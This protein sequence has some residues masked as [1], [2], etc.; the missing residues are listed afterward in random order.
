MKPYEKGNIK[1]AKKLRSEQTEWENKFWFKFLRN[2]PVRFQ[3]QKAIGKYIV[4]F[5]CAKAKLVIELDGSQH[6]DDKG[7]E[8]DALRTAFLEQYGLKV[9]RI[10]NLD[11]N[12]NFN[13]IK[14]LYEQGLIYDS[15]Q[16][17]FEWSKEAARIS[18]WIRDNCKR[19]KM[20]VDMRNIDCDVN[21]PDPEFSYHDW[22]QK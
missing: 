1:L 15:I 3:R 9:I 7:I 14:K 12:K 19:F 8:K 17:S 22:G 18:K 6:Y 21:I 16:T 5:Y 10:S 20:P 13:K 11:I 4:D 2:Y